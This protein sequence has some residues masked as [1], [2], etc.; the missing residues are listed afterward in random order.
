[1]WDRPTFAG[2][3]VYPP[4]YRTPSSDDEAAAAAAAEADTMNLETLAE[5]ERA[6][7]AVAG[8]LAAFP[9]PSSSS[10]F[11]G[12]QAEEVRFLDWLV[13]LV[14]WVGGVRTDWRR[15]ILIL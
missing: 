7:A 11:A 14:M 1:M 2:R 12:V 3:T 8:A 15:H 6:R 4:I 9:S 10:S 5:Q 13:G